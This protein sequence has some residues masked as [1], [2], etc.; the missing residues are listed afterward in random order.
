MIGYAIGSLV[1]MIVI[2]LI[3]GVASGAIVRLMTNKVTQAWTH[4]PARFII[5]SIYALQI[6]AG[7]TLFIMTCYLLY[8]G[9]TYIPRTD[10]YGYTY[11]GEG[12]ITTAWAVF[13]IMMAVSVVADMIKAIFVLTF[14]D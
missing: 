10:A 11:S 2:S 14:A 1:G 3:Y 13:G 8:S 4:R 9:G 6:I 5:L 7:F 12:D